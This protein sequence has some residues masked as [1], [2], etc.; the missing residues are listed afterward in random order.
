VTGAPDQLQRAKVMID[1][2]RFPDAIA[3]L[4]PV[5]AADPDNGVAWSLLAQAQIGADKPAAALAAANRAGQL[6]PDTAWPHR[7]RSV[8]QRQTGRSHAAVDSAFEACKREPHDWVN[9]LVL[10]Q[11]A[12]GAAGY[13]GPGGTSSLAIAAQASAHA[14]ALGPNEAAAHYVSGQV[15]RAE[16]D[17]QAALGYFERT[18]ALDPEHSRALNELGRI[19]LRRGDS[20]A[21]AKHFVQA[22]RIA[23]AETVYGHNVE[24]AVAAA[25]RSVRKLVRWVIYGSW[26]LIVVA[27]AASQSLA[28]QIAVLAAVGVAVAVVAVVWRYQLRRMPDQARPL[29]Q[30]RSMLLALGVALGALVLA[31]SAIEFLPGGSQDYWYLILFMLAA[32]FAA[33]KILSDGARKRYEQVTGAKAPARVRRA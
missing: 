20:G 11:A 7:L 12:L 9:H 5:I 23:P 1:V 14:R 6:S 8:A 4:A 30:G 15:S 32:R 3:L 24:I 17:D 27:P 31:V 16:G 10:A 29:F 19:R 21:A 25:E 26:L 2:G 13:I 33:F 18:L 28:G 22:A